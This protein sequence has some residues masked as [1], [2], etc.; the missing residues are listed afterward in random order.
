MKTK[1]AI[2]IINLFLFT[3]TQVWAQK[4][5]MNTTQESEKT[6]RDFL[7]I[8]RS[9]KAPDKAAEF[10]ADSVKANQLNAE[11]LETI[12]RT[13]T[14]YTEHVNQY[15]E[16]YGHFQFKLNELFASGEKVYACWEQTGK[17]IA[18]VGEF[19]A[20]GMPVKTIINAVFRVVNKKIVEYWVM[21][22][23]KGVDLQLQANA[24]LK[25]TQTAKPKI[26]SDAI[27]SSGAL[28]L[29]G[30]LGV[31]KETGELASGGVEAEANQAMKNIGNILAKN[32]LN[33]NNLVS[34]TIYLTSMGD[35]ATVN[36]VYRKYFTDKLPARV[37]IAVRELPRG[38][39]IEVT[40]VAGLNN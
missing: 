2:I 6:V 15:I 29:S 39:H 10:L 11:H 20:T 35:Y 18:D 4:T 24:K 36:E 12:M 9:G 22:D 26:Y 21:T 17:Q 5:A 32:N 31:N 23:R 33:Y 38:G 1:H 8:V 30:Q 27:L 37:C 14:N 16:T 13:P 7:E 40:G 3:S 28:Y 34:V 25:Q 19:K